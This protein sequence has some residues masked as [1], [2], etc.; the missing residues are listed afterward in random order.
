MERAVKS[1]DQCLAHQSRVMEHVARLAELP[2]MS[3]IPLM[4]V[5]RNMGAILSAYLY[6]LFDCNW[7]FRLRLEARS[8]T[9][10]PQ[11]DIEL[12]KRMGVKSLEFHRREARK[13]SRQLEGM[14]KR[15]GSDLMSMKTHDPGTF[16]AL[17]IADESWRWL[18]IVTREDLRQKLPDTGFRF[19][20]VA[21]Q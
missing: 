5:H 7:A 11:A 13:R 19:P 10:V 8:G 18:G 12:R 1:V 3:L 6:G 14:L 2:S 16:A 20:K 21:S 17:G 9:L 15:F 4:P